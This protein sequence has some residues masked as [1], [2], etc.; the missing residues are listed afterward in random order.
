MK[1]KLLIGIIVALLI[2]LI[3]SEILASPEIQFQSFFP[4]LIPHLI[5][6]ILIAVWVF[7][8]WMVWKKETSLFHDQMEP[9]LAER[10]LRR[11]K[12]F[13]LLGG[14]V[15]LIAFVILFLGIALANTLKEEET[16]TLVGWSLGLLVF[17]SIINSLVIFFRGRRKPT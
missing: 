15:L 17:I 8:G 11:L 1:K 5:T 2:L 3:V 16:F 6:W 10:L 9:E 7:F 13:I 14:I 4:H 12:I